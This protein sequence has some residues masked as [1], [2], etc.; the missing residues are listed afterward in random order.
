MSMSVLA[1]YQRLKTL[2]VAGSTQLF[3]KTT[4]L[5][6]PVVTEKMDNLDITEKEIN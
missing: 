1:R 2:H 6:T 3:Y 4:V 5:F